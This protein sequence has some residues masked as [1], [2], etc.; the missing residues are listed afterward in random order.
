M[1][2]I[3]TIFNQHRLLALGLLIIGSVLWWYS[4]ILITNPVDVKPIPN[5]LQF[6]GLGLGLIMAIVG[7]CEKCFTIQSI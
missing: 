5:T 4:L 6:W 2:D 1:V 3:K 7:W